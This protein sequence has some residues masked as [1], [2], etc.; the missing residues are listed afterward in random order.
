[1]VTP[2]R[3]PARP[4]PAP[5]DEHLWTWR[6]D[7]Y[8]FRVFHEHPD[9]PPLRARTF[10]P[11]NRFDPHVRDVKQRP[12][13]QA[14]GRGVNYLSVTL[15][16]ALAEAFPDEWPAVAICPSARV[17]LAAPAVEVTL[18][19]LT[20]DGALSVG[21]VGT[22]GSGNEPR[23]LT[24]R[25]ARAI[26]EDY[27][28]LAGIRYRAAHQGGVALAVWDR[29][30]VLHVPPGT[31]APPPALLDAGIADRVLVALGSQG[32]YPVAVGASSCRRCR[33]ASAAAP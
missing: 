3:P 12:R 8:L 15:A 20:G 22:L 1:V 26:Y 33:E 9:R 28:S 7:D 24:Q 18:L 11:L 23:R 5:S 10:G 17:V 2:L 19:D 6:P 14:E 13:E 16:C 30:G 32:R 21:A 31:V 25:W 27:P 29:A 4:L